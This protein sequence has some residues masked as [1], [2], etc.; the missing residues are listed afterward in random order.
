MGGQGTWDAIDRWPHY[1][2]AAV[3]ISGASDPSRASV[4]VDLPIWTFHGS[5]DTVVS[6]NGTRTMIAAIT[7]VGGHPRYRE[8]PGADHGIWGQVYSPRS[9]P[10]LYSW[11]FSQRRTSPS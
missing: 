1:F 7:A 8:I 5:K 11:L 10:E 9:D 6:V 3:P 4:L 2:A